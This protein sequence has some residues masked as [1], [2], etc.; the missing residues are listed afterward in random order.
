MCGAVALVAFLF[1]GATVAT[2]AVSG[3]AHFHEAVC[4]EEVMFSLRMSFATSAISTSICLLLALPAAYALT[5]VRFPGRRAMGVLMELTLSLPYIVL[6]F[7][8]LVM[9]S[10]PAGKALADA[11]FP[12]VFQPAGIVLAQT[13]VNLPFALRMVRTAMGEVNP[14]IEFVARTLGASSFDVFRTIVLPLSRNA[15]ISAFVLTWARGMGE[16]GAT[17][18]L[19]GV[20]RMRTETLPGSIY[21]SISTGNVDTAMATAMIMLLVSAA[22][23]VLAG[24]LNRPSHA[25][26]MGGDA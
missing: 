14:R 18:M 9:F 8:L 25:T 6:G 26:R 11:G 2:I 15:V 13:I 16:F 20:T 3:A 19:V 24:A 21:L 1:V 7:A 23:L 5:H 12:V 10:S 4:S 17:L 22:A